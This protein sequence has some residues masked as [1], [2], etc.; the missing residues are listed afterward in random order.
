M[1]SGK[2][3]KKNQTP[4]TASNGWK[5]VVPN[6]TIWIRVEIY[7]QT[8]QT[9]SKFTH[10]TFGKLM[11]VILYLFTTGAKFTR[12]YRKSFCHQPSTT[13]KKSWPRMT[14]MDNRDYLSSR[15]FI[16]LEYFT[17][18]KDPG[19]PWTCPPYLVRRIRV[20]QWFRLFPTP[21]AG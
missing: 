1:R 9:G 5:N 20:H 10:L 12:L 18:I 7:D 2:S 6:S 19:H 16:M 8:L 4:S 21:P 14:Q 15:P 11:I 3:T 17:L 13:G